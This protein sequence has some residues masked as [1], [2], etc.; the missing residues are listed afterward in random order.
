VRDETRRLLGSEWPDKVL[1]ALNERGSRYAGLHFV[2]LAK[3]FR[4]G[5]RGAPNK[6]LSHTLKLLEAAGCVTRERIDARVRYRSTD[7]GKTFLG[8]IGLAEKWEEMK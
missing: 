8:L 4:S 7:R 1:R 2:E 5:D 6:S 3:R